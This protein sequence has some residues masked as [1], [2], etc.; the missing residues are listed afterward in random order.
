MKIPREFTRELMS[1]VASEIIDL[2]EPPTPNELARTCGAFTRRWFGVCDLDHPSSGW[3]V[4]GLVAWAERLGKHVGEFF[5][6][7]KE[8]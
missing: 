1:F 5:Y 4:I 7:Q 6:H 2:V 8:G 3:D